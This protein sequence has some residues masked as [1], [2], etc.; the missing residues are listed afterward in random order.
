MGPPEPNRSSTRVVLCPPTSK[1]TAVPYSTPGDQDRRFIDLRA[2]PELIENIRELTGRA[3]MREQ[4]ELL[5]SADSP[6]FSIGCERSVSEIRKLDAQPIWKCTSYVQV[7]FVDPASC[8]I[9]N[10]EGLARALHEALDTETDQPCDRLVE[11]EPDP[12]ALHHAGRRAWSLSI[13]TSC[14]AADADS[15][16]REWAECMDAQNV[17]LCSWIGKGSS[18]AMGD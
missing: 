1:V 11:L 8:E 6:F 14:Y 10:Y 9:E 4:V 3:P 12:V 13:W 7:A 15:S 5:N 16:V 17:V 18:R 2:H